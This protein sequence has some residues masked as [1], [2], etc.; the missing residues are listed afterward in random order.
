MQIET[1]APATATIDQPADPGLLRT[2]RRWNPT[3]RA[4]DF[5]VWFTE[6][7]EAV[8]PVPN[9]GSLWSCVGAAWVAGHESVVTQ[10]ANARGITATADLF[11]QRHGLAVHVTTRAPVSVDSILICFRLR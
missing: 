1:D 9:Q 4:Y 8:P 5:P 7:V 3:W 2:M 6:A 11:A 10:P